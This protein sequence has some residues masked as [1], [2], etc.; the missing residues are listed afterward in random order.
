M[1]TTEVTRKLGSTNG[2]GMKHSTS[3]PS[4]SPNNGPGDRNNL[5]EVL[6]VVR[7]RRTVIMACIAVV[8]II[9]A[10]VIF[11]ITPRYTAESAVLLDTR[12]NQVLDMHAVMTGLQPDDAIV[13]SEVEVLKSTNLAMAVV[14][15]TN[16]LNVPEFNPNIQQSSFVSVILEP[17]RWVVSSI[18]S[19]FTSA[20]NSPQIDRDQEKLLEV[21]RNLEKNLDVYN[22]GFSYVIKIRV[23][24]QDPQ[25]SATLANAVASVYLAAQL[26]AKFN[27]VQNANEW[28]TD[29]LNDLRSK[30]EA[31]D[32]AVQDFA[33]ANNLT[34][35]A[36]TPGGAGTTVTSQQ[37]S[38]LNTQLV[39][40]SADLAQ[41]QAN[42]Q[43]VQGSIQTGNTSAAA[44]VLSSPLIQNLREQESAL[45]TR[46]ADLATRYKPEHPAMINI[47]AQER[48]LNSKIQAE[49]NRIVHG[50]QGDVTAGQAKVD[51]LRQSLN[52]LQNGA[53][54]GAGVQLRELQR[55]ADANRT[56]Y[57][58]L[59]N[60]YKQTTTQEDF[61]QADAEIISD[62]IV[63]TTPSFP[64]KFPLVG[65]AFMSS[66]M[67][68]LFVAFGL[69]RLDVG[70]RTGAQFEKLT[71]IPLLGLSP[72]MESDESPKDIV[73]NR[74]VSAYAEAI[75][76]IRTALRYSDVDNPPKVVMITSS[77]PDEGKTTFALS[78]ARSGAKS[79]E[80][81]LLI[82]CDLRRP[83]IGKLFNVDGEPG[84]LTLFDDKSSK[85]S[86]TSSI[87]VDEASGMHFIPVAS[88]TPNPQDLLGSKHMKALLDVMRERYDLI[89]LDTPPLLA[90]SDALVLSHYADATIF[91]SR[92]ARTPRTVVF[93][94][95]KSFRT[96]GTKLAGAVLTRVDMR[97]HA[98][99]GYGDPGYYYGYYG[100]D[101]SYGDRSYGD[102]SNGGFGDPS[103]IGESL[104]K[105]WANARNFLNRYGRGGSA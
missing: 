63:P 28:L 29:H 97:S 94:A 39:L 7:R 27:A 88:K 22:D 36:Q 21:T 23:T 65:F 74:P 100:N 20:T 26:E 38:E 44:Q 79:G 3:S 45:A 49:I 47:K 64:K 12:K 60:R 35:I 32:R 55:E 17:V 82:D 43:Q 81:V 40:A 86:K 92:W 59:L 46:E 2:E 101:R 4:F 84:L 19:L 50:M 10:V 24:S 67:V 57:E 99:Y 75:R 77:L 90:V 61:Q 6:Q 78:F 89:V 15:K 8:T 87:N 96:I 54:G 104:E 95:L 98:T 13:R 5:S 102:R 42:L 51:S 103:K 91:L 105:V 1:D 33:A 66:I 53:Q 58:S 34:Q 18:T 72:D 30:V 68:G 52:Q 25:L 93:G 31:S 80:R 14:K 9:S 76:S 85:T 11:N 16:L 48:D 62:A 69:E 71:Q 70:F 56:L 73:I 83:S 37:I 41:K